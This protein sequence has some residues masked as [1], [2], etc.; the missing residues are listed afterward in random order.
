MTRNPYND[1]IYK[2]DL[3]PDT[4]DC[5]VFWTKNAYPMLNKLDQI[6]FPYYFQ[7]TINGYGKDLET[8]LPDFEQRLEAFKI[9]SQKTKVI[10]RYDPIIFTARYTPEWHIE[11]FRKA[12]GFF[13]GYTDRCVTSFVDMYGSVKTNVGNEAPFANGEELE[14]FIRALAYI[15]RENGMTIRTCAE[16]ID[17]NACGVYHNQ[18]IDPEIISKL[19]G[20]PI[21]ARKDK[22]QRPGC[23]CIESVEV[24][25]YN[26]CRHGC[27][28]CYATHISDEERANMEKK[29]DPSSPLLCDI[30]R[31]SDKVKSR[32]LKSIKTEPSDYEQLSLF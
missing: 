11:T 5:I 8:R 13:K 22:G 32:I 7:Y 19:I 20:S 24:G 21:K 23:N 6:P 16:G 27:T 10:W 17:F 30:I 18:C 31:P 15:A 2:I 4:V 26:T 28:Y 3:N 1:V 12:A 25:T 29:Y 9:I 14:D